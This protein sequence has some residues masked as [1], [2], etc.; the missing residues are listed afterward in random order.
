MFLKWGFYRNETCCSGLLPQSTPSESL[1]WAIYPQG[2]VP[3]PHL[4]TLILTVDKPVWLHPECLNIPLSLCRP[5]RH[6]QHYFLFPPGVLHTS[7]EAR[8]HH[9]DVSLAPPPVSLNLHLFLS[10]VLARMEGAVYY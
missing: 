4:L 10:Y 1:Y 6:Q 3:Q 7:A 2:G 5:A 9:R 8:T